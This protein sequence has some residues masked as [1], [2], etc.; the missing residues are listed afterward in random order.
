LV[1]LYPICNNLRHKWVRLLVLHNPVQVV[2]RNLEVPKKWLWYKL[3]SKEWG[4]KWRMSFE[5]KQSTNFSA[6]KVSKLRVIALQA[7]T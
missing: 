7:F 5:R 3:C 6:P 4:D 2:L 1:K